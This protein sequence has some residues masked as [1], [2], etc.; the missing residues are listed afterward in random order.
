[1]FGA[2]TLNNSRHGASFHSGL[3]PFVAMIRSGP[4]GPTDNQWEKNMR[5]AAVLL[6]VFGFG[7]MGLNLVGMEFRLL[8]WVDTWGPTVGWAIRAALAVVGVVLFFV[9]RRQQAAEAAKATN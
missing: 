6:M 1:M 9:D 8:G 7:S 4:A 3:N 5:Q 2:S